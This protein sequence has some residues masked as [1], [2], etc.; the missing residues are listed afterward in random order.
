MTFNSMGGAWFLLAFLFFGIN[1]LW[2]YIVVVP[3]RRDHLAR[4]RLYDEAAERR[5]AEFIAEC[6]RYRGVTVWADKRG[7]A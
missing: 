3:S 2:H 7:Q 5:H 4:I 6:Q 1:L